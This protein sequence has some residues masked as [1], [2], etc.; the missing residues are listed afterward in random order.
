MSH[1]KT[2]WSNNRGE[3]FKRGDRVIMHQARHW[4]F[5]K[6]RKNRKRLTGRVVSVN[7]V[8]VFV[9]PSWCKWEAHCYAT[10]LGHV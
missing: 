8:N 9:R 3:C 5:F 1:V 2:S 6:H 10:E 7:G 4:P